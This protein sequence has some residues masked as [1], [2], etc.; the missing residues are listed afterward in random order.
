MHSTTRA[1]RT[2]LADC[3]AK[4]L[5]FITAPSDRTS[6]DTVYI[7]PWR[8]HE[9]ALLRNAPSRAG[10]LRLTGGLRLIVSYLVF[11]QSL[12]QLEEVGSSL[13]RNPVVN[14]DGQSFT[15]QSEPLSPEQQFQLF[16]A[17]RPQLHPCLSYLVRPSVA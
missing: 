2:A 8:A 12:E 14:E 15:I 10:E 3:K 17:A 4:K 9:E 7:W 5:V 1:L 11:S 16:T 13:Y 6:R